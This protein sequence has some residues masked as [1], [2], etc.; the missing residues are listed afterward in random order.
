MAKDPERG[1][2]MTPQRLAILKYLKNNKDHPS[3]ADIYK[4]VSKNFPTMSLATVY[5]TLR[6]L[7]DRNNLQ[8]IFID[9]EKSR[10]DPDT[11][12]HNHLICVECRRIVDIRG[13]FG[14]H[15]PE[16]ERQGFE[17]MGNHVDFYG[18]CPSC[19]QRRSG[20][21]A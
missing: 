2:K 18:I 14:F 1:F 12:D 17:I 5:N 7:K 3:A 9:S 4:S 19:A 15:L 21:K 6:A 13:D 16:D 11:E 10:F 8:E 20:A